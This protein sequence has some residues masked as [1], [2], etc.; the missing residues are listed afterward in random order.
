MIN[1]SSFTVLKAFHGTKERYFKML[2]ASMV[3]FFIYLAMAIAIFLPFAFITIGIPF[4][5]ITYLIVFPTLG[6][7]YLV[8]AFIVS[9]AYGFVPY[10][11]SKNK[12]LDFSDYL[13]NSR[14]SIRGC[15]HQLFFNSLLRY[16]L[17][18]FWC[19]AAL[20][21]AF[22]VGFNFS[23]ENYIKAYILL[24][25]GIVFAVLY[26]L[27]V[28]RADITKNLF[29]YLLGDDACKSSEN[30][31]VKRR[32]STKVEYEPIFDKDLKRENIDLNKEGK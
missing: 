23:I 26:C 16:L 13:Y 25:L 22:A 32:A 8:V 24:G 20:G 6:V 4:T 1:G 11:A 15:R 29:V 27:L 28:V 2:F 7:I 3:E 10:V 21:A 31:I 12:D 30:I 18:R 14:V 19:D 17:G 9:L 5:D